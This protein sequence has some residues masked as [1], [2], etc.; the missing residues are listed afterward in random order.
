MKVIIL[1][2][3]RGTRI[4]EIS[5]NIPKPMLEIGGKPIL[6]HIMK[7]YAHYGYRDFVL[8]L[9]YGGKYIKD[10]FLKQK[11]HNSDFVFNTKEGKVLNILNNKN[12]GLDDFNISFV[13][14]GLDTPHGERV[15]KLK[16]LGIKD[17]FMVT[18]GDGI[19]D[20]NINSLVKF[21]KEKG[22]VA[23]ITGAHPSSRWGLVGYGK[24]SGLV[25]EFAQKPLMGDYINGGF[26]VCNNDF[27][28]FIKKGEMIE[29]AFSRLIP[30]KQ[31]ALYKHDG[32]WYGMDTPKDHSELNKLWEEGPKW[33]V[34]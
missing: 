33:K 19:A 4:N 31:L 25:T 24:K 5:G 14:T 15:L 6:W 8:A 21:H 32:F 18:Y 9:G 23:T 27:F 1:C 12:H 7:I 2:G 29:E 11:H 10:Y 22:T 30:A 3:G 16:D 20:I 13:D 28:N 34:W 17:S 26:M